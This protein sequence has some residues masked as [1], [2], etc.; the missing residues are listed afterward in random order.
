MNI[1][2]P[3]ARNHPNH[4]RKFQG[5]TKEIQVE[6]VVLRL[7]I[8]IRYGTLYIVLGYSI[9]ISIQGV[10]ELFQV[11]KYPMENPKIFLKRSG[12][13]KRFSLNALELWVDCLDP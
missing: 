1:L 3:V 13:T 4:S 5:V 9:L 12:K 7:L 11:K 10:D 8:A 6:R 2:K